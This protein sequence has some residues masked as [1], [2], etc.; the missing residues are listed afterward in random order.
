MENFIRPEIFAP[1]SKLVAVVSTRANGNLDTRKNDPVA[2]S[3]LEEFCSLI[4]IRSGAIVSMEQ[5]H[6]GAV[7]EVDSNYRG[8][9]IAGV[10]GIITNQ[11]G[12]FLS[13]VT[14]DCQPGLVLDPDKEAFGAIH[15]GWKSNVAGIIPETVAAMQNRYDTDPNVLK[16]YI[17]PSLCLAHSRFSNPRQEIP[18][19][20]HDYIV[21]KTEKSP[22]GYVDWKAASRDQFIA[23]GVPSTNIQVSPNCTACDPEMFFSLRGEG[24]IKGEQMALIGLR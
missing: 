23:A 20:F 15:V 9:I 17:G 3:N 7:T 2:K 24:E 6:H 16:V 1:Y 22:A 13:V 8:Q 14:A 4:N 18:S 21:D 10:D 11:K 12:I 5:I 19:V